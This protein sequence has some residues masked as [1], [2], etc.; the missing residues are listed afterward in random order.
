MPCIA[1]S[2]RAYFF[3]SLGANQSRPIQRF[4]AARASASLIRNGSCACGLICRMTPV[5]VTSGEA[6]NGHSLAWRS[7]A[8][9][10]C[11]PQFGQ[12]ATR[13]SSIACAGTSPRSTARRS[14]SG[15]APRLS[16]IV[17][18]WPQCAHFSLSRSGA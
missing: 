13:I 4:I 7:A 2:A 11:A 3:R 9:S 16:G 8:N 10:T 12:R 15:I 6:Q 5:S 17:S 18:S 14:S 1:R